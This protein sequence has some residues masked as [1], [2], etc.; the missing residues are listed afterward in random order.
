MPTALLHSTGSQCKE[1]VLEVTVWKL[2]LHLVNPQLLLAP[3]AAK[4]ATLLRLGYGLRG[5]S[6]RPLQPQTGLHQVQR[7]GI[8]HPE[9]P[10]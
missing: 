10:D 2:S 1:M 9:V 4:E 3:P 5:Q 7:E 6:R 8:A